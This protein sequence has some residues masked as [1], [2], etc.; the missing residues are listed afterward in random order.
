MI[1]EWI[2]KWERICTTE[3]FIKVN[4]SYWNSPEGCVS[5]LIDYAANGSLQ[6]L[7]SSLGALPE[8]ILKQLA[9]QILRSL[10]YLHDH[11]IAHNN[12]CCS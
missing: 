10:N 11:G 2:H 1:K 4:A 12:I 5:V 3:Q 6:N 8:S 9:K 7:V